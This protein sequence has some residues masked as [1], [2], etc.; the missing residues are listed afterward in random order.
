MTWARWRRLRQAVQIAFFALFVY[1]LFASLEKRAAAPLADLFFRFNP[2]SALTAM[3][4]VENIIAG[5]TDKSNLWEVNTE[6][7][8]HEEKGDSQ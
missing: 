2:L 6:A 5:T 8:Y 1:L 7:D 3:L 4:A